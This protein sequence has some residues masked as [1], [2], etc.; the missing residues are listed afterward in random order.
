MNAPAPKPL[1]VV[2][3]QPLRQCASVREL[4]MND[5]ARD[6]LAQV[7]AKHLK[8]ERMMRLM[9]NALRTTPKL[10]E[11]EPMSLLGALMTTASLGLEPNTVLGHAYLIPFE[12]RRKNVVE[13]QLVVG[14]KGFMDLARRSGQIVAIHA[15]VVYSDDEFWSYE[16]GSDT[17]LRHKPGPRQ[18]EKTHAYCHVKLRDGEAFVVLPWAEIIKTRDQSQ[19]WK[20]AV[21]FNK[22]AES[23]WTVHEDR[24][25]AKTAVRRMAN[26]GEMPLS[27][28][29][30]RGLDLDE[31]QADYSAF[32]L[33]PT[34]GEAPV[35][36]GASDPVIPEGDVVDPETGEVTGPA[37]V[38]DKREMPMERVQPRQQERVATTAQTAAKPAAAKPQIAPAGL[39]EE[40]ESALSRIENDLADTNGDDAAI[41]AA[42][43]MWEPQIAALRAYPEAVARLKAAGVR[44]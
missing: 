31:K 44:P 9:A 10:G 14:Y 16:Y 1:A 32:A 4:L 25:A 17:H 26:S 6:Q 11:C 24:M 34:M 38:E 7:A 21:R 15:D 20:T 8:P 36:E 39:P 18:G 13:V 22:T 42:L 29:L 37:Q 41:N 30:L 40:M 28:E 43:E 23:P 33:N 5:Q 35:I 27:V 19:G 12:N 3:T 2:K